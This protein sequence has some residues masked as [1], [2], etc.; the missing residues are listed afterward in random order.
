MWV[1]ACVGCVFFH[2]ITLSSI[3]A[4]SF[5]NSEL[6]WLGLFLPD[7]SEVVSTLQSPPSLQL[8]VSNTL[9]TPIK[10]VL[11]HC[12][13]S[14]ESGSE[15]QRIFWLVMNGPLSEV[16]T[17]TPVIS[18]PRHRMWWLT[19]TYS[20]HWLSDWLMQENCFTSAD[21]FMVSTWRLRRVA[22]R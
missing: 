19:L 7:L 18:W 4:Q 6:F 8:L 10:S 11:T 3:T 1:Y 22:Q 13:K 2:V 15:L 16:S 5:Y 20:C 9:H 21:I 12:F 14:T 17:K